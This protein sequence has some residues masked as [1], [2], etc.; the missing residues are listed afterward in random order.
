MVSNPLP[1]WRLVMKV[2]SLIGCGQ[3][4]SLEI[5]TE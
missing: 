3:L 4:F 1:L 5:Y 2:Q